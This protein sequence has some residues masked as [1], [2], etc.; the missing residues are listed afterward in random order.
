MNFRLW[1]REFLFVCFLCQF[2][3]IRKRPSDRARDETTRTYLTS[4]EVECV[5]L[6]IFT[7]P[8]CWRSIK[9]P[10]LVV[11]LTRMCLTNE[12]T[13]WEHRQETNACHLWQTLLDELPDRIVQQVIKRNT[14]DITWDRDEKMR[15]NI[16]R[17]MWTMHRSSDAVGLLHLFNRH[18]IDS[19]FDSIDLIRFSFFS[20]SMANLTWMKRWTEAYCAKS[21]R[22]MFDA[23]PENHWLPEHKGSFSMAV[24]TFEIRLQL[25]DCRFALLHG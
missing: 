17:F 6:P 2:R 1:T 23:T 12:K 24:V 11:S 3:N 19:I 14:W 25:P 22:I 18:K 13:N 20:K 10:F 15:F 8:T 21:L 7:V 9:R 4:V 5:R 16:S